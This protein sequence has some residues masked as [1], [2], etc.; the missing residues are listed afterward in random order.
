MVVKITDTFVAALMPFVETIPLCPEVEIGLGIPR[1][2]IRI[3]KVNDSKRLV[4]QSTGKI[5]PTSCR[6]MLI[7]PFPAGKD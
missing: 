7:A 5:L 1:D 6:F 4:Q 3:V 2:P